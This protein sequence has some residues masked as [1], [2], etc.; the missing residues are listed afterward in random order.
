MR[1]ATKRPFLSAIAVPATALVLAAAVS[2]C[3]WFRKDDVFAQTGD[4]R[5]LEV[6]PDLDVPNT[7]GAMELP[8]AAPHSVTRSTMGASAAN[9]AASGFTAKGS[10]D[11]VF[12][13]VGDALAAIDGVVVA[14]RAQVLGAY[15]VAYEGS[16]FLVRVSSVQDGA[17]VSAVDPRGV[18]ATSAAPVKLIASLKAALGD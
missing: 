15:D 7:E 9:A 12:A 8:G 11:E 1:N 10:R 14:S 6:P 17:Y 13:K 5:P 3:H 4:N 16:N 18:P 2:G